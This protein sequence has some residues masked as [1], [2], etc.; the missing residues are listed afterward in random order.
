MA[1]ASALLWWELDGRWHHMEGACGERSYL[2]TGGQRVRP[3]SHSPF[4]H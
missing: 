4:W 1:L 2:Q 3:E